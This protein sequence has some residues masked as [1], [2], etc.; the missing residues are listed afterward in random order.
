MVVPLRSKD[1]GYMMALQRGAA[2]AQ[3]ARRRKGGKK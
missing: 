3:E 2:T 1:S